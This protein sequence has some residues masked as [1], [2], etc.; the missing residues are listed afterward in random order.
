LKKTA[1]FLGR[2]STAINKVNVTQSTVGIDV[3]PL[4][5]IE[6]VSLVVWDFAGQP[7]YTN[8]HQVN[9]IYNYFLKH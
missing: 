8:T 1:T 6:G 4:N 5:I 2:I 9:N 3:K 7:Q